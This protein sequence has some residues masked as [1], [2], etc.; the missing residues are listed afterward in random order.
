[1]SEENALIAKNV[2]M[3]I[4]KYRKQAGLS[5]AKVA[6]LLDLSIDAISRIERGNIV[7]NVLRLFEFAELFDCEPSDFLNQSHRLQD[8]S[9][10]F[11]ELLSQLNA[12]DRVKLLELVEAMVEWKKETFIR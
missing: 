6:E 4:A 1:M 12:K 5:Q 3:M 2:G 9:R 7:P 8:Q 10:Q 11:D